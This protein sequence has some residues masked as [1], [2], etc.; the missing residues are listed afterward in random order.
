MLGAPD[1][2]SPDLFLE[3]RVEPVDGDRPALGAES[4][5][6]HHGS[7]LDG[8][9]APAGTAAVGHG[10]VLGPDLRVVGLASRT[11][12]TVRQRTEANRT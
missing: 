12:G 4:R 11:R 5:V 1:Y 10:L 3:S 7:G 9:V 8:E 2:R 6:H